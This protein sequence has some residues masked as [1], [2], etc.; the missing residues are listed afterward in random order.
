MIDLFSVTGEDINVGYRNLQAGEHRVERE[1]R[2]TLEDL[3]SVYEPYA[4]PNFV[5]EFAREPEVRFWEMYIACQLLEAGRELMPTSQRPNLGGQPDICVLDRGRRIW[6]EAVAPDVGAAGPDQVVS[7]VPI[8]EGGGLMPAPERQ[9][10][11]R[12]TSALWT[13]TQK[14]EKYMQEGVIAP[15]EVALVAIGAGRFGLYISEH[16]F[17][18]I[19]SSVFPIGQ[20]VFVFDTARD[21]IVR[22]E[23][24][25]SLQIA[26]AAGSIPRTAFLDPRFNKVSG[27][28]WSRACIGN[29]MRSDRPISFVHNPCADVAMA[30]KWGVW[31][32]EFVARRIGNGWEITDVLAE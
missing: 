32:R 2:A 30:E 19:V 11:L 12:F 1:I 18:S 8:N 14:I 17:P 31:D 13:K 27:L 24:E 4:D 22:Q 7:P 26:R 6:I 3:W 16:P 9:A 20:E 15:D 25:P 10:Q 21:E 29:M 23:F 5:G 28:I